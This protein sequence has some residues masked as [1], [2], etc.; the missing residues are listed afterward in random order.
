MY[1][2]TTKPSWNITLW[3]LAGFAVLVAL[4]FLLGAENADIVSA[5]GPSVS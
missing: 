4:V 3:A 2:E 1:D 5:A